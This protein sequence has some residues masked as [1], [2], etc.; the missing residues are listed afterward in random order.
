MNQPKRPAAGSCPP[1]GAWLPLYNV[2]TIIT[3][4]AGACLVAWI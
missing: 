2:E 3:K 4:S 1:T